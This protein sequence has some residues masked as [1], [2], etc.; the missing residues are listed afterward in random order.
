VG[1]VLLALA[2]VLAAGAAA[3]SSATGPQ[4]QAPDASRIAIG[5]P[6]IP[7]TI[8]HRGA[9]RR[10][11]AAGAPWGGEY[12]ASSG[13]IVKVLASSTYPEDPA[14]GQRWADFVAGLVHGSEL[15]TITVY[16]APLVEVQ[17]VCGKQA[18]ACYDDSQSMLIAP[19]DDPAQ[20]LSAEAVVTHE[21][22]HHVA[23]NRLNPPWDALDWGTKRWAT[24]EQVCSRTQAGELFPGDESSGRYELNPGEGFAESY[25]VMNERKAQLAEPPWDIVDPSLAPD[26]TALALLEQDVATPWT[27][28][29]LRTVRGSFGPYGSP[30][31]RWAIGAALDGTARATL[32]AP[33]RLKLTVEL[34]AGGATVARATKPAGATTASVSTTACGRRSFQAVV[35]RRSGTGTFS[36]LLSTP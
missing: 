11:T 1:A 9:L 24:Y 18:L 32:R 12:T 19:G 33:K 21:Y 10:L 7:D 6:R 34:R 8:I 4:L 27:A 13:E 16:L 22:G 2:A 36:L 28:S 31:R 20:D 35:T 15:A 5:P 23:A 30:S 26:D 17:G 25:R 14:L 29:T 3:A